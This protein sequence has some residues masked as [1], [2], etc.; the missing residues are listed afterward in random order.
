M[1]LSDVE[2]VTVSERGQIVLPKKTRDS[3]K[4]ERGTKLLLIE[5][6]GTITLRKVDNLMKGKKLS[7]GLETFIASE[8]TLKK[9]WIYK[10]D[11]VWD[12]L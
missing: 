5:E 3:M 9:D 4:A 7:E 2:I 10:G 11:D 6:N 12:E 8:N 1:L